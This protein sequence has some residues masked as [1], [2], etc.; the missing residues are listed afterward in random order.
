MEKQQT[1][2][3]QSYFNV[4]CASGITVKVK[5]C[6]CVFL[7]V[8]EPLDVEFGEVRQNGKCIDTLGRGV[9][10]S[11]GLYKC[12]GGGGNQVSVCRYIFLDPVPNSCFFLLC[13]NPVSMFH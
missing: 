2:I 6:L 4:Q 5:W 9:G 10:G 12:H 13:C 7:S 11:P 1:F 8:P 3:I